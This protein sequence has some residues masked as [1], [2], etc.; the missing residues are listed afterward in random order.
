MSPS[1]PTVDDL[2]DDAESALEMGDADRALALCRAA[3]ARDPDH[4]GARFLGAESYRQLRDLDT[5]EQW[6]RAVV[7]RDPEHGPSWSG[8][9][10]VLFDLLRFDD[11]RTTCLRA[12]RADEGNAEAYY[13]RAMLRERRHDIAGARRDFRRAQAFD[14][15]RFPMPVPLD[16]A[17]VEAVVT[18]ALLALHPTIRAYL[19]QVAILLEEV[20]DEE[21]CQSYDPPAPPG[22]ILGYFS[23]VSLADRSMDNPWSNL[24]SAIVL[25]RRNLERIAWDR[26]ALVEELR[27]TVFHEVGHFLGLD[28]DDLEARG[29][30]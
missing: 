27:I 24:P 6:Y 5:A 30:D 12:I 10:A 18:E 16:D 22:E 20:P 4:A 23:G 17:T 7:H 26:Q 1:R 11:A 28:E 14:P 13:L 25:F 9:A 15:G 19:N 21:L 29:L 3:L 2:L 8:L